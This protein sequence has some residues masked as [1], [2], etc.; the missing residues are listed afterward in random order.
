[1]VGISDPFGVSQHDSGA[2]LDGGKADLSLLTL[3]G[4]ALYQ[5]ALVGTM[6]QEKYTRGGF[7]DVPNGRIRYTAAMLRHL[8]KEDSEKFDSDPWYDTPEGQKWRNRIRHDAQ[9][10]WNAVARLQITLNEEKKNNERSI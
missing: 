4:D 9:T 2:K 5:I 8:F 1:M 3:M 10:A 6:G 7:L